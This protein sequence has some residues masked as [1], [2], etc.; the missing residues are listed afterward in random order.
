[1]QVDGGNTK[2][3]DINHDENAVVSCL[4]EDNVDSERGRANEETNTLPLPLSNNH[5]KARS[6]SNRRYSMKRLRHQFWPTK[7]REKTA[8]KPGPNQKDKDIGDGRHE[9]SAE[10]KSDTE[11]GA[12]QASQAQKPVA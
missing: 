8:D 9:A 10:T 12:E 1:M 2:G 6:K 5:Q 7:T 3:K 4:G 11:P